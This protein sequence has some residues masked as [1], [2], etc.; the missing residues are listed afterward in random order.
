MPNILAA[1]TVLRDA[2]RPS[3]DL[4][5]K[6]DSIAP[7]D[8]T[9]KVLAVQAVVSPQDSSRV[10]FYVRLV[11][12]STLW[13]NPE[14]VWW[15]MPWAKQAMDAPGRWI[16]IPEWNEIESPEAGMTSKILTAETVLQGVV[17][18]EL[19]HIIKDQS[20]G[21]A[22]NGRTHINRIKV[23]HNPNDQNDSRIHVHGIFPDREEWW[24]LSHA[25]ES[26]P[27]VVQ[28][29][30]NPG[31]WVGIPEWKID[32]SEIH[33]E[34]PDNLDHGQI[35]DL[36]D[37]D[38]IDQSETALYYTQCLFDEL[39]RRKKRLQ[40][41]CDDLQRTLDEQ[42]TAVRAQLLLEAHHMF[43]IM[44][45]LLDWVRMKAP[46]PPDE[47]LNDAEQRFALLEM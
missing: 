41:R 30:S 1:S 18:P 12:G 22:G 15:D 27:W 26:H 45:W 46:E 36:S 34:I 2:I 8:S 24:N 32:Q 43:F 20:I 17:R 21:P 44:R 40:S 39:S 10:R 23:T 38:L 42:K 9:T 3:L 28:A 11:D 5:I 14:D 31:W 6:Q 29:K 25:E 13:R 4:L 35:M 33:S 16:G 47:M 37:A 19:R 7:G